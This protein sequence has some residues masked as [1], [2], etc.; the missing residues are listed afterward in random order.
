[1][2]KRGVLSNEAYTRQVLGDMGKT[3]ATLI[4]INDE[5][6]HAWRINMEAR[7]KYLRQRDMKEQRGASHHLD[8]GIGQTAQK[9]GNPALF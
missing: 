3:A 8:R 9:Q 1:V 7:G 5:A 2:D 4:V 6:H